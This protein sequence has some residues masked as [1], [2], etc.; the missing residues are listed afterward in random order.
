MTKDEF[1][2]SQLMKKSRRGVL[3]L[4][5]GRTAIMMVL[6]L[7]QLLLLFKL[8]HYFGNSMFMMF[9]GQQLF[10]VLI[11][12]AIVNR[13]DN[14]SIQLT[15]AIVT[16]VV[17]VVG[18]LLYI[19]IATRPEQR[20]LEKRLD[21]LYAETRKYVNQNQEVLANLKNKDIGTYHMANYIRNN[22]NFAVYQNTNIKYLPSG[23]DKLAELLIQLQKAEKF[24]FLEYFIVA[25]GVMWEQILH[26]LEQK[27]SEG[28]EVRMMYDGTCALNLLPYHYPE[29]LETIGIRCKMFAPIKPV[30]STHYNNRDHRKIAVIDG[31]V[32]FTGGVNIGDEYI[33]IDSPYGHWKDTAIMV[34][35]AAVEGF[36]QMFLQMW[37]VDEK[38]QDTYEK[39]LTA[40]E[41]NQNTTDAKGFVL[42][43]GDSPFDGEL[44]GETVY[45]DMLNRAEEYVHIMT[46]YLI[47]DHEMVTALSYAAKR[48]V[49][50]VLMLPHIPDKVYAF[51]LAKS[52][53][54]ELI[55]AG[56]KIYEYTPGFVHAKMFICDDKKAVVGTI[57]LDYRSLY[58]HFECGAFLYEVPEIKEIEADFQETL[59]KCQLIT[60]EDYK[61][62]KLWM[63]G[64]GK[65]L[66]LLA[67]LM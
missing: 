59:K 29:M 32:A 14:P 21:D 67:P 40:S 37:N 60:L 13:K 25:K 33:N 65:A 5:F 28:V 62:T 24:I 20:Q 15:W 9:G 61:K 49:E 23:E 63:K 48:G 27:V 26:V 47:L 45:L 43:Y 50:V 66:K 51:A 46:P 2:K 30:L 39:Y 12:I 58:L 42:P 52:H 11:I 1:L 22:G 35:G 34:E 57:N 41:N 17:P 16:L 18:G 19:Y 7:L 64:M 38:N 36:T 8:M 44:V 6:F 4:I 10:A 53:Y 56:V 54:K 55:L 31:K 3:R